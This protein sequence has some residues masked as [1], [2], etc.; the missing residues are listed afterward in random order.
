[1][2]L[3][4]LLFEDCNRQCKGCCNKEW[5]LKALPVETDFTQY[6]KILL[7]GGEPMID[8]FWIHVVIRTI[9]RHT[10]APIYLY[11]AKVDELYSTLDV[12]REIDG[13]TVTLHDQEDVAPFLALNNHISHF[14]HTNPYKSLRLNIFKGIEIDT[15]PLFLWRIRKN[16]VWTKDCPLPKG[17]VFKRFSQCYA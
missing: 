8:P 1:M 12:L 16:I 14:L 10:K 6:S 11:T 13:M 5:D 2:K 3:R 7:T 4:L 15:E 9:R 17:E